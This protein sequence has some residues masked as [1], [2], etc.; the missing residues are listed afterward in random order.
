[1]ET[2]PRQSVV[3]EKATNAA[4]AFAERSPEITSTRTITWQDPMQSAAAG[5][6]ISASTTCMRSRRENSATR[7]P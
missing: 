7:S 3:R 1:M 2:S 4:L 5:A 6:G